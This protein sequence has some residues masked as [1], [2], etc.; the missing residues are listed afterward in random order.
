MN[1]LLIYVKETDFTFFFPFRN[2]YSSCLQGEISQ[3][4][5]FSVKEKAKDINSRR[6]LEKQLFL[7]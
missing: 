6:S 2:V 7:Q 5:V 1:L 4:S 3:G